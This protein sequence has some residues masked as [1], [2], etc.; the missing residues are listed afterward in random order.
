SISGIS[1]PSR[2]TNAK[3]PKR[4]ATKKTKVK[5]GSSIRRYQLIAFILIFAMAG[6]YMLWKSFATTNRIK[7]NAPAVA[8]ASAGSNSKYWIAT[9]DGGV[10]SQGGATFYGSMGGKKLNQPVSSMAARPQADGYWLQAGDC[11]VFSFGGAKYHGRYT[12]S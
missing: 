2:K 12:T 11:G 10:F 1:M 4:M 3:H 6:A 7:V 5:F 8:I 9:S